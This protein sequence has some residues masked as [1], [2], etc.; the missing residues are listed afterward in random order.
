MPLSFLSR[1]SAE[2]AGPELGLPQAPTAPAPSTSR[3]PGSET[4]ASPARSRT[5]RIADALRR[6]AR[7]LRSRLAPVQLDLSVG[8]LGMSSTTTSPTRPDHGHPP[9]GS[10]E[11]VLGKRDR[12]T[13]SAHPAVDD[14]ASTPLMAKSASTRPCPRSLTC[15]PAFAFSTEVRRLF[16]PQAGPL[17][18][19][20]L[21]LPAP[22]E[23]LARS[24][25]HPL[26]HEQALLIATTLRSVTDDPAQALRIL[27]LLRSEA[28][29]KLS[30]VRIRE[31]EAP[32]IAAT[33][34]PPSLFTRRLTN[35]ARRALGSTAGGFEAL[36]ALRGLSLPPA[37]HLD[38]GLAEQSLDHYQL[39]LR[40][41]DAL[42]TLGL[43]IG[44]THSSED[45]DA[46]L[47]EHPQSRQL[48]DPAW[49]GT[50]NARR[51]PGGP[52]EAEH[53]MTL[54]AQAFVHAHANRDRAR[55]QA[56]RLA[57]LKPASVALRNGFTESGQGS[58]F[59]LMAKRL[60]KFIT[61]IDLACRTPLGQKPTLR[62]HLRAPI[63]FA[64]RFIGKDK[65]PLRTLLEAG[66]LAAQLGTIPDHA[67]DP[68]A[69]ELAQ[70]MKRAQARLEETL[71]DLQGE[72]DGA[73]PARRRD[74][75]RR[76]MNSVVTGN[77]VA[78]Y[79]DGRR[80]GVGGTF[81]YGVTTVEGL[82]GVSLGI[83]PVVDL[84][85]DHTRAAVLKAGPSPNSGVIFLGS[86]R[87]L[88]GT[89]GVG[90]RAGAQ[91][92]PV[93][94]SAQAMARLG[95][96]H[97]VSKGLMIRT[98]RDGQEHLTLPPEEAARLSE[99]GWKRMGERVVNTVFEIADLPPEQRP[100]NGGAMWSRVVERLGEHRDIS[101][102]WN[103]GRTRT[104]EVAVTLDAGAAV[105]LGAGLSAVATAG[106][107]L[108]TTFLNQQRSR[109]TGGAARV[110]QDSESTRT[111]LGMGASVGVSHPTLHLPTGQDLAI[112][113]RHKV[114]VETELLL[115]ASGATVRVA[116]EGGRVQ[117]HLSF[118][119]REVGLPDEFVRLVDA[120]R[121]AWAPRL[122]ERDAQGRLQGGDQALD[123]FLQ[124]VLDL[125]PAG[126]R[127]YV[128]VLNL[129]AEAGARINAAM[130]RIAVL[131]RTLA[132]GV[133]PDPR[134][135]ARVRELQQQTARE[136]ADDANW[137]PNILVANETVGLSRDLGLSAEVRELPGAPHDPGAGP[138]GFSERFLGG[139]RVTLGAHVNSAQ[140]G[141][142][143]LLLPAQPVRA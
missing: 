121:A 100:A 61:Y 8:P 91:F 71:V 14:E 19:A 95:G 15:S 3:H 79:R 32:A 131:Q 120:R 57:D 22:A 64:R 13:T 18:R 60:R 77:D 37:G 44:G 106:V 88:G 27:E 24:D 104:G 105:G 30:G 140:S 55:G 40:A 69:A 84:G 21:A 97:L 11:A 4:G 62:D 141:R 89:V 36:K 31:G 47:D 17:T 41:E 103:E 101:F 114:G 23:S 50:G 112:F 52:H 102:G 46:A 51:Q 116:T 35:A 54:A 7:D 74:I 136:M 127:V 2:A 6:P 34:R 81:G 16:S 134:V 78:S 99:S 10:L 76:V 133:P 142:D 143:L 123:A 92:G 117:P 26:R 93:G 111:A 90:V 48:L 125:P 33:A 5:A 20:L 56:E 119:Q 94:V 122:G 128:E 67:G 86:E 85:V 65:S 25:T 98:R 45:I 9:A 12:K 110:A 29:P 43:Q 115:N 68:R 132:P 58:A 87:T 53:P 129:T 96:S 38:R 42:I 66:P 39:A 1:S 83:T 126:N 107:G 49:L 124:R 139:G 137:E 80:H 108:K 72:F 138:K 135:E 82:G 73:D 130:E 75:L 28:P 63:H 118:K 59:H 109:D 113:S 70:A